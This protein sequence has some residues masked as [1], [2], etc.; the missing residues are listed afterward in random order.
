MTTKRCRLII[1]HYDT[2]IFAKKRKIKMDANVLLL[3]IYFSLVLPWLAPC[4]GMWQTN[5]EAVWAI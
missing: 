3:R 5:A 2:H 1:P 4:Y